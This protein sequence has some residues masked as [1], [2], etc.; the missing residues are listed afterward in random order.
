MIENIFEYIQSFND[1]LEQACGK[2]GQDKATIARACGFSRK[3]LCRNHKD[4]MMNSIDIAKFCAYTKT[5][6][7]W[8][9]GIKREDS[10]YG[11]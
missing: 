10:E 3:Q 8:L 7:N 1:R 5:D 6:A 4:Y 9:L 2:T 11:T